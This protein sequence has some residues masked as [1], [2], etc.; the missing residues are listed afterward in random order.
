M[1]NFN[2]KRVMLIG[3]KGESGSSG[4]FIATKDVTT[5]AQIT[6]AIADGKVV[7]ARESAS[8]P[9]YYLLSETTVSG[10]YHFN[11][12]RDSNNGGRREYMSVSTGNTWTKSYSN[13]QRDVTVG[14][15]AKFNQYG[16][17]TLAQPGVDYQSPTIDDA[18]GYFQS[19]T[20]EGVLQEIGAR[21]ASL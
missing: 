3:L 12:L 14:G 4:I 17:P 6:A 15:I 16:Y 9:P 21:L 2:T 5:Y 13:L 8:A 19:N 20:I 1:A 10:Y 11:Q 18:G 7:F